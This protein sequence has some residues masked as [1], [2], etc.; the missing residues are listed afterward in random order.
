[1]TNELIALIANLALTLSFIIAL[2]FGIV[3]VKITNRD[4]RERLTLDTL[5]SFE[6]REF[7]ELINYIVL[8]E[9]PPTSEEW[10]ALPANDRIRLIQFGQQMESLGLLLAEHL[11]NIDVVDKTLGSFVVTAWNKYKTLFLDL[12]QK[13]SDP[14]LGEY[15]Q[16]MAEQMDYRMKQ[17]PRKPFFETNKDAH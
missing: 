13:Q 17:N 6:T 2:I 9:V 4:R 14:F 15:F 1:M 7:A 11:I 8:E 3:Q 10:F 12:R 5:R 16:W